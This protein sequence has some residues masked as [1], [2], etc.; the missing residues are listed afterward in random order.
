MDSHSRTVL[1]IG[2]GPSGLVLALSLLK[3]GVSVR[4]I[5]KDYATHVGQR[6][7]GVMPR[8]LELYN[9]LGILPDILESSAASL[10]MQSYELPGGT[11]P[12]K[13]WRMSPIEEPTSGTPWPNAAMIAQARTVTI[14]RSHLHAFACDVELGTRLVSFDQ[15]A[16]HVV[17]NLAKMIDGTEVME[18]VKV[19]WLVGADGAHSTVRK[20]LGLPFI[21]ETRNERFVIA[22]V[23]L[24]GLDMHHLHLFGGG[25]S[26]TI[27]IWP[28]EIKSGNLM[29]V[30]IVGGD[31]D[32]E[33]LS[34]DYDA[35][36]EYFH[37]KMGRPDIVLGECT[38]V[39]DYRPSIRMVDRFQDGR[40]FIVG[41]AG[42]VHPLTGGQGLNTSIQDSFNLAWKLALVAKGQ[43]SPDLLLSYTEERLPVIAEVL[44]ISTAILNKTSTAAKGDHDHWKRGGPLSQLGVNYR[45]S[46]IVV[47]QRARAL[48]PQIGEEHSSGANDSYG[49]HSDTVV[50]AGDRA[51]DASCL[52]NTLTKEEKTL[53]QLFGVSFHT[54]VFFSVSGGEDS[55]LRESLTRY[56]AEALHRITILSSLGDHV[57]LVSLGAE[58][59][60][61]SQGHAYRNY[62]TGD[63]S[64]III[65]RPDGMVGAIVH[66]EVGLDKYFQAI[67]FQPSIYK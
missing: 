21:G 35:F 61:D 62:A 32:Y 46:S 49:M 17:A 43:A 47:D 34:S 9:L 1:V 56:P 14:L 59:F 26:G 23:H 2:A 50:H 40:I 51:P 24:Q 57:D 45:W 31:V 41:D 66:D 11:E 53:F 6:G 8:S 19:G 54:A 10:P 22:D 7:A 20:Q 60:Y 3:N 67:T 12:L 36:K 27:L 15:K 30:Y 25:P 4:I 33:K 29:T 52:V 44:N 48:D 42:H 64:T 28:S 16:D 18:T 63:T 58:V 5:E 39:T 37:A 55:R 38:W 65:V 13:T